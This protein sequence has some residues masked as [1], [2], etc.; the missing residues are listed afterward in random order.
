MVDAGLYGAAGGAFGGVT[1]GGPIVGASF[2]K[3]QSDKKQGK[4]Q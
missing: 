4:K 1:L 3:L 2:V